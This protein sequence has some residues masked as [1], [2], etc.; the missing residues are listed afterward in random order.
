MLRPGAVLTPEDEVVYNLLIGRLMP[1][2]WEALKWSQGDPDVSYQIK[3]NS[4][5]AVRWV[6]R[7]TTIWRQWREKS[8]TRLTSSVSHI[9]VTDIAGFYENI[10]IDRLL[11]DL[12]SLGAP[13]DDLGLLSKCLKRWASQRQKGIPQG[14]TASDILA[15]VYINPIDRALRNEG[16]DHLRYVDDLRIFA[17]SKRAA[18]L[19]IRR[20]TQLVSSRGL[21]LQSAKT[22]ILPKPKAAGVFRGLAQTLED[23]TEELVE[24]L[25][26]AEATP[27]EQSKAVFKTLKRR[28]SP[29]PGVLERAFRDHFGPGS[30]EPFD[31]SLFHYLLYRLGAAGSRV[32]VAYCLEALQQRPEE[33]DYILRYFSDV[34]LTDEELATVISFMAS[35]DAIYDYQLYQLLQW[36]AE[37]AVP[38]QG[39]VDLARQWAY[40]HNREPWL[41]M[42]AIHYLGSDGEAADLEH[43]EGQ[44]GALSSDLERATCVAALARV[45]KGRRNAF[46]AKI[47]TDGILVRRAVIVVKQSS[48]A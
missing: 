45:E 1:V 36:F 10:D 28:E 39:I 38:Y 26:I 41:R 15:K 20:L 12:R 2:V 43:L 31:K 48:A 18:R 30:S 46:F 40:D 16:I 23:L 29:P 42:Y 35:D 13:S 25:R 14:Y 4:T 17:E 33:T 27:Y 44:Y 8:L 11:S 47:Q 32:A 3:A 22:E 7:D 6:R 21:N 34:S 9:A 24:E 19:A 5:S 37:L